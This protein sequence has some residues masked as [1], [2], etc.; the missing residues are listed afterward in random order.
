MSV[1][2]LNA[3]GRIMEFKTFH[4]KTLNDIKEEAERLGL[5]LKF[6]DNM[7]I[8]LNEAEVCGVRIP[9]RLAV[10]PMEG[11]DGDEDES[12]GLL[13]K[14]RYERFARGGAGLIW[15]EA[16]AVVPEGKASPRQLHITENNLSGFEDIIK[17]I[18]KSARE[19][20]GQRH[21][22]VV[23]MQLTHSGRFSKPRGTFE[24]VIACKNPFMENKYKN[25][26]IARIITDE[27]LEKLEDEFVKAALLAKKAGFD[28]VDIKACHHYL[29]SELLSAFTRSGRYG[30]DFKGRT[31]F[32]LNMVDKVRD[33]V[34][35][36]LILASRLNIYDGMAYP[37]GWGVDKEDYLKPDFTEPLQLAGLL[38]ER[39]VRMLDITM[40]TPYLNPHV[41]R[42]Y[43]QGDY[44]PPEH[45]LEGAARMVNGI[46]VIQKAYP[47][48]AIVG[49]GY[50]YLRHF[51]PYLAAGSL[52]NGL[53]T[54]IG[55]GRMALAYPDFAADILNKGELSSRKSCVCCSK[56]AKLL[57]AGANTGCVVRDAE[58][59][60]PIYK[61]VFG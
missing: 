28:G 17:L 54:L 37:Y 29:A 30:G 18:K 2:L 50:T 16:V 31:R 56:C 35:K 53:A 19:V 48:M 9:N 26:D 34:G 58:K 32:L 25:E 55:F 22:P 8:F 12:P 39:G 60:A 14:R 7:D 59:Y 24:P 15:F 36:D 3:G 51:S 52:E 21:E 38:W 4:Y 45:P 5:D 11:C 6:S 42:P 43:D 13:T 47:E 57:R 40:G 61:E 49:T 33:A 41:N 1:S 20:Y 46:G 44:V 27:E 23:I 10:H